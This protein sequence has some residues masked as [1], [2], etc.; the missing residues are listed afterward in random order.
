MIKIK[1]SNHNMIIIT[2]R[3]AVKKS[4]VC[5]SGFFLAV[6]NSSIGD[7]VPCLFS[8]KARDARG[9]AFCPLGGARE[10][11][12]RAGRKKAQQ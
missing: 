9:G 4:T 10:K 5:S 3:Q 2:S 8:I 1:S 6:H 7:L 12:C 11:I